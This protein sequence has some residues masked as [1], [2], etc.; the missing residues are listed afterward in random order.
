K[1]QRDTRNAFYEDQNEAGHTSGADPCPSS[2]DIAAKHPLHE[3]SKTEPVFQPCRHST[4]FHAAG[5]EMNTS[6]PWIVTS[7]RSSG[8]VGG[9]ATTLP[10]SSNRPP[11]QGHSNSLPAPFQRTEHD[12]WVQR[13][14]IAT[15][16]LPSPLTNM[17]GA[18][19]SWPSYLAATN[20][21]AFRSSGL[22]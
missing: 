6:C 11:W 8:L 12:A 18:V 9:P 19:S 4:R 16:L 1:A 20:V 10:F 7:R 17:P 2:L 3:M 15:R 5:S 13:A 14:D 22:V 21:C